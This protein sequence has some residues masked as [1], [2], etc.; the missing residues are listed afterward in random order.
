MKAFQKDLKVYEDYKVLGKNNKVF[1][2]MVDGAGSLHKL[3][4]IDSATMRN[5]IY[6]KIKSL[7]KAHNFETPTKEDYA[8]FKKSK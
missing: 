8:L 4:S 3:V 7:E 1:I 5:K 6:K 2:V